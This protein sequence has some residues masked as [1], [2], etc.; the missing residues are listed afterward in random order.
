METH[1]DNF[2]C[3]YGISQIKLKNIFSSLLLY[4]VNYIFIFLEE[5]EFLMKI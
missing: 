4:I 3:Q 5:I 1:L 2:D